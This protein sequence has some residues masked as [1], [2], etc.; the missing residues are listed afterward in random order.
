MV[1]SAGGAKPTIYL[2]APGENAEMAM[3]TSNSIK[4]NAFAG[5]FFFLMDWKPIVCIMSAAA[6]KR[7]FFIDSE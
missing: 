7:T 3:T 2:Q 1:G 6:P 5:H 4:V